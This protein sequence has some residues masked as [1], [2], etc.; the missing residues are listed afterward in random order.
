MN[1]RI[2]ILGNFNYSFISKALKGKFIIFEEEGFNQWA[3][4]F[5]T[6]ESTLIKFNPKY[7]FLLFDFNSSKQDSLLEEFISFYSIIE[8]FLLNN[9]AIQLFVSN[10]FLSKKNIEVYDNSHTNFHFMNIWTNNLKT[11][12]DKFINVHIVDLFSIITQFGSK[13]AYSEKLM[14]LGSIPFGVEISKT[15]SDHIIFLIDKTQTVKHKVLCI[16]LDN[17]LWGGVLGDVGPM[18]IQVG[19][20]SEGIVY[21]NLQKK[22]LEIKNQGVILC[23]V[24][25]NDNKIVDEV[26]ALNK[27]LILTKD[28]FTIIKANWNNKSDNIIQIS[29]ELNIGLQSIVFIDDNPFERE[30]VRTSL[31]EVKVVDFDSKSK[32]LEIVNQT[33]Q[34]YFFSFKLTNEDTNKGLQY[35]SIKLRNQVKNSMDF[36]TYLESLNMEITVGLMQEH[37]K[38]RVFQLINKTN[39]FNLTSIRYELSEF[40][41]FDLAKNPIFVGSVKDRFGDE[42]L[43]YVLTSHVINENLIIDNNVMS[44]RVMG[45]NIEYSI[46]QSIELYLIKHGFKT[47]EAKYV[48]SS[49]NKPIKELL[50]NLNFD[51]ISQ[52]EVEIFYKKN[53]S[54]TPINKKL[55][56]AKWKI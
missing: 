18:G 8:T 1:E 28:D 14:L 34:N 33:F 2:A 51:L 40:N 36:D 35:K 49:K 45:R 16:D 42:G 56:K 30:Q 15:I 48:P 7:I 54:S 4:L 22:I 6:N 44:C 38:D 26:F 53:L 11:L 20:T 32:Y 41:N 31:P 47:I 5:S 19:N 29:Q 10:I 52:S 43:I 21:L 55:I 9:P 13:N 17:T 39:Q 23:I 27:N 24:S 50:N 37:E 12:T 46:F 3:N 25:K